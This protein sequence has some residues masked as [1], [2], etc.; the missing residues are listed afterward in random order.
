MAT[1][2]TNTSGQAADTTSSSDSGATSWETDFR[3]LV[4]WMVL[5]LI[6]WAISKTAVGRVIIYYVLAL[7]L[8]FLLVTQFRAIS[9]A[10]APF[11]Q[12]QPGLTVNTDTPSAGTVQGGTNA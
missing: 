6:L 1:A 7:S 8:L 9:G 3:W 2:S 5:L 10:L 4:A 12:L 11:A